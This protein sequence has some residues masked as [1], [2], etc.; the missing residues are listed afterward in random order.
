MD[1]SLDSA[2]EPRVLEMINDP[3]GTV[4]V[5]GL[6]LWI[7][8]AGE[9]E[10]QIRI[11]AQELYGR[12]KNGEKEIHIGDITIF[13]DVSEQKGVL[14]SIIYLE[15]TKGDSDQAEVRTWELKEALY[16]FVG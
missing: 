14:T 9:N 13:P 10:F 4:R 11:I 7:K 2:Y 12:L 16:Y 8:F 15:K 6:Y 3:L 1:F 5:S